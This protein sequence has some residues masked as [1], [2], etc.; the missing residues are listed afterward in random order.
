[1]ADNSEKLKLIFQ[2]RKIFGQISSLKHSDSNNRLLLAGIEINLLKLEVEILFGGKK[3]LAGKNS[4]EHLLKRAGLFE[5]KFDRDIL[6]NKIL[7]VLTKKDALTSADLQKLF[8]DISKRSM[9]RIISVFM[10]EGWFSRKIL[11][12]VASYY[13]REGYL[14][15]TKEK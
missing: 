14:K 9:R 13:L 5:R 1:M 12:R 15:K 11:G 6:K 8:P 10:K 4:V 2:I 3:I 7:T